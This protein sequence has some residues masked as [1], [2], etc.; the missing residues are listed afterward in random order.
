MTQHGRARPF[1][2]ALYLLTVFALSWPLQFAFLMLGDAFRPI[3]LVSMI[4]AGAGTFVAG[5][6]IFRDGFEITIADTV[7]YPSRTLQNYKNTLWGGR[8]F[9]WMFGTTQRDWAR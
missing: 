9:A 2:V 8:R 4:M 1:S 6:Y 5:R 3:L 7:T